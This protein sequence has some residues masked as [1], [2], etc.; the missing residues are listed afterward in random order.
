MVGCG[1]DNY[2][3]PDVVLSGNVV[4][5]G[6]N[7]QVMG[8]NGTVQMELYQDGYELTNQPL[9]LYVKQDGSFQ[10]TLFNGDYKLIAKAG[11]GSWVSNTDTL[12]INISGNTFCEYEV[13]PY[14]TI[15]DES[16]SLNGNNLT[17]SFTIN[18]VTGTEVVERA[19][20]L[21]NRTTFVDETA[22]IQRIDTMYP[23][24][25][26]VTMSMELSD[27]T[28]SFPVLNARVGIK[29]EGEQAIYCPVTNIK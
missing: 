24:V 9:I 1:L 17:V 6:E 29:R 11:T 8:S 28:L 2:D 21:V 16:F 26:R 12:H 13:T 14:F 15:S 5:N 27:E 20:L 25:G 18:D 23:G 7:V 19:M 10:T 22:Q 4:Y 3:E